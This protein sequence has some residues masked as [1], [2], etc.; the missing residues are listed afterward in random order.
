[1]SAPAVATSAIGYYRDLRASGR[2]PEQARE[3]LAHTYGRMWRDQEDYIARLAAV[4]ALLAKSE[5]P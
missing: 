5:R 4:D 1:M 3:E 2:G